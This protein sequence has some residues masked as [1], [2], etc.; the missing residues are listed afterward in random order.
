MEMGVAGIIIDSD[1]GSF[2]HSLRLAPVSKV[3]K[4]MTLTK[5]P[6]EVRPGHKSRYPGDVTCHNPSKAEPRIG[7][8]SATS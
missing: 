7:I 4:N 8:C 6:L 2:P 3:C 5:S 1:Y